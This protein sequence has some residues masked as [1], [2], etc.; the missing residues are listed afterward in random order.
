MNIS[1]K[2]LDSNSQ[3]YKNILGALLPEMNKYMADSIQKL[4]LSIPLII[5]ETIKNSPEYESILIGQLKYELGIP[6]PFR[7]LEGIINIWLANIQFNYSKPVVLNNSI[8]SSF[9]INMIKS[10]FS[11]VLSSDFAIVSD[12]IRNYDLP[13]L[14]WLLLDGTKTIVAEQEVVLGQNKASRT[15]FAVMRKSN[16]SWKVPAFYAGTISNNWITRAID[17][18]SSRIEGALMGAFKT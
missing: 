11:D 12:N 10:D 18:A 5:E 9:S 15:G 16:K 14:E 3:I 2:L 13:W 1:L 7:K 8:K 6:D 17:N 4:K